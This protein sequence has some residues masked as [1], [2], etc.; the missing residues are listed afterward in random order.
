VI[1]EPEMT[2]LVEAG[3]REVKSLRSVLTEAG[4]EAH[5]VRPPTACNT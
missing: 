2:V 1:E 4:I 5:I 3:I